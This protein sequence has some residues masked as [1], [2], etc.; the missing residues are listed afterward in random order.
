MYTFVQSYQMPILWP[1]KYSSFLQAGLKWT[2]LSRRR[3]LLQSEAAKLI[4]VSPTALPL[5][6]TPNTPPHKVTQTVA[7]Q[8]PLPS[9]PPRP[10]RP[11]GPSRRSLH[12]VSLPS[13][14]NLLS[15]SSPLSITKYSKHSLTSFPIASPPAGLITNPLKRS[16][17]NHTS[18][19]ACYNRRLKLLAR[20]RNN[21]QACL[22]ILNDMRQVG[23]KPDKYTYSMLLSSCIR[24]KD[25]NTAIELYQD[26]QRDGITL[27][28]YLQTNLL[29]IAASSPHPRIDLCI[30]FF[31]SAHRPNRV[32]CNVM[33]DTFASIGDVENCLAT[34][35]FMR[36]I[37]II[38]DGYTVSAILKAYVQ[39]DRLNDAIVSLHEMF[40][41]G[42]SIPSTVFSI[43]ITAYGRKGRLDDAISLY[44]RMISWD[45][46]PSQITYNVLIN[47]CAVI[48]DLQRAVEIY[49]EMLHASPFTG[50]R[51]TMH[52]MM[53]CC[54][55][56]GDG[57]AALRWYRLI[58]TSAVPNQISFRMALSAAG[59]SLD[60][61]AIH[62]ITDDI[63]ALS[64][65]P[66]QDVAAVLVAA[67]I[68]CSDHEA[69]LAAFH[70]YARSLCDVQL[71]S[72]VSIIRSQL[73]DFNQYTRA[74]ADFDGTCNALEELKKRWSEIR[75]N[76]L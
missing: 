35:R 37:D 14:L 31:R 33:M 7:I 3:P 60:L 24:C 9:S 46:V 70:S 38:P 65:K 63:E 30:R 58:K 32:L 49:D 69:A 64:G 43:L 23:V 50:D 72:F 5:R 55:Y 1:G 10:S 40:K 45:I 53:K 4:Q 16:A 41:S 15:V 34:Y 44:D 39:A 2:S 68:Q 13:H 42:I 48:G 47:A 22:A 17:K 28:E 36:N 56:Q 73:R 57:Q 59:H 62:E 6:S 11:S 12:P 19:T 52:G 25:Q 26:I 66:R 21:L 29:K 51:Y 75:D 27:D 76:N 74:E 20:K 54:L 18:I 61:D 8:T 71:A 67:N